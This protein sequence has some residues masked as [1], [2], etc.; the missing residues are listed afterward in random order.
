VELQEAL[1][2]IDLQRGHIAALEL[3]VGERDD[4]L[5]EANVEIALLRCEVARL[6]RALYGDKSERFVDDG[7]SS[8]A[9]PTSGTPGAEAANDTADTAAADAR[10]AE[11]TVAE[12]DTCA[13]GKDGNE[14]KDDKDG[15]PVW[16]RRRG[17]VREH[18][19][20]YGPRGRRKHLVLDP[21]HVTDEHRHLRPDATRCRCCG[22]A[23][24]EIGEETSTRIEREPTRF[25]RVITHR[26]KM[27]CSSCRQ[28]GVTIALPDD[29]PTFGA[30][31]VGTSLAVDMVLMHYDDHLPFHRM[32]RILRRDGL[33]VDRS[34]LSRVCGRVAHVLAP[35]VATMTTELLAS[36]LVL[37]IDGTP[38]KV[39]AQPHC[40]RREVYVIHDEA[41]VVFRT[42]VHRDA[43]SVLNG[44]ELFRGV[45][46]ADAASVHTGTK[47]DE[48]RL[49]V[50]LCNAH[51][52][53]TFDEARA[54]DR[55][56]ADHV[57]RFYRRVALLE[58]SWRDLAPPERQGEREAMLAPSFEALRQWALHEREA[59]MPRSPMRT[60]FDYLLTHW[61]GLTLFLKDGRIP[62]TNN[63]S[64]RLLR[65]VAVGR[66]AWLFRGTF[67]GVRRACVLW[68]LV[69]SCRQLGVDPRRY[70]IDTLEALRDT[71]Y[72]RLS[73]LTPKAYAARREATLAVA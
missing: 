8:T 1:T 17:K 7:A 13:D 18:E 56:R 12:G 68:S 58:R 2:I 52:R 20:T 25:R 47:A 16:P 36:D 63:T 59:V 71:P 55:P 15:E 37:G 31:M 14:G 35:I 60:A 39:L 54:T 4:S 61:E 49:I 73:T 34:T 11:G 3:Q 24:T 38:V 69:M 23:L 9:T 21:A 45:V 53:R 29:P 19:R 6:R 5:R 64:E 51:A 70:L 30:G 32:A 62:W 10:L 27:A 65:H 28:G 46:I 44:F 42:M 26:H 22:E 66:N 33:T 40:T 48:M 43:V 50:A 67:K 72:S 41:H 57:L